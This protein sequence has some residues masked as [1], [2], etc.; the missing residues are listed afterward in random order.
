MIVVALIVTAFKAMVGF[1]VSTV[2]ELLMFCGGVLML[3]FSAWL[4]GQS[5]NH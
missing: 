2:P 4:L 5:G 3:S 1:E